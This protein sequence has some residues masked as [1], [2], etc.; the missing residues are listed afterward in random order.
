MRFP[1]ANFYLIFFLIFSAAY[2]RKP[3][4]SLCRMILRADLYLSKG[5]I[6]DG[7]LQKA[8][9][10]Y[11]RKFFPKDEHIPSVQSPEPAAVL[12]PVAKQALHVARFL[13][14]VFGL[15]YKN[16]DHLFNPIPWTDPG[17]EIVFSEDDIRRMQEAAN[18]AV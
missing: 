4:T 12:Q 15:D 13:S 8:L 2:N 9:A 1:F 6:G 7:G 17:P 11:T 16:G 18:Q 14:S 3:L 5:E 10:A